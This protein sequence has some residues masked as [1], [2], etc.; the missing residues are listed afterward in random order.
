MM[1]RNLF[2][3]FLLLMMS[4]AA[5]SQEA[6]SLQVQEYVLGNGMKVWLNVDHSQ[7]K[8]FGAV[9]VN[10]GAVDCPDTGIAHYFE[11][12]MFKG[13][14][15]LGTVDYAAERAYLDSISMKYD[16]L[17]RTTDENHRKTIQHDINELN[18][19][20]SQYAIPNEFNRLISKYGGSDLNAGTSYDMTYY[21]NTFSPQYIEQW[22]ELN[23]HR[24]IHP[25]YRLFQGELETVYEEKNMYSDDPL[26]ML[27][28]QVTS[29]FF[30]GTP[31][32][33]P[34][35]GSTEN[36]KNPRLSDMEAFYKKFYVGSNMGL[37]LSGDINPDGLLPVLERTFG[38]IE[39][40]VKPV[41][42]KIIAPPVEG[43]PVEKVLFPLPLVGMSGLL[44]RAPGEF[45]ADAPA[46]KVVMSLLSNDNKTGLLDELSNNNRVYLA[47]AQ[48]LAFNQTGAVMVLV[49]PKLLCRVKTAENLCL[50]QIG[51][52]LKGDFT[53]EQLQAVKLM[54]A[55]DNMKELESIAG[56]SELMVAAMAAGMNWDDYLKW[57]D[58]VADV[59]RDEVIAT[60]RKYFTE[61]FYRF[62]KKNGRCKVEQIAKPEFTAVKPL[63][64]DAK[65]TFAQ[66]LEQLPVQNVAPRLLDLEKDAVR[67]ELPG[68][69]MLFSHD[70]PVNDNFTLVFSFHKGTR[71]D[72]LLEAAASYV[73]E[74]GTDSLDV[75]ALGIALQTLGA[76]L[77]FTA[78][79]QMTLVALRGLDA[80]FEPTLRLLSHF[81]DHMKADKDK[82]DEVKTAVGLE[83]KSF[84]EDNT[85]VF[86]ALALKVARGEQSDYLTR[87][88]SKE[89]KKFKPEDL[90]N[91]FKQLYDYRYDVSYT[92]NIPSE[93]VSD[94]IASLLPQ[95]A[96]TLDNPLQDVPLMNP[97]ERVVYLFDMPDSRQTIV[98]L[99]RP[100]A[101]VTSERDKAC[102]EWWGEYFGGGMS[103]VLFQQV[104]EFRSLAYASQGVAMKPSLANSTNSCCYL[105]LI[106]T[107]GDKAMQAVELL[108]SLI[109]DMPVNVENMDVARQSL[110]N[111]I[112]NS[113][114]TFRGKSL[115]IPLLLRSGYHEDRCAAT[116]RQLSQLTQEDILS[117]YRQH[118]KDQ[119]CQ[120]MIVGNL[121]KMDLKSLAR[122]G[123]I[124]KVKKEDIYRTKPVKK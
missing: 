101:A 82:F 28:E 22:C 43:Q 120:L 10:A 86:G 8:V 49:V 26:A 7:P 118:V 71:Q 58:H 24:L 44:F 97:Q 60:A 91:S 73:D 100:L 65:S 77:S 121:K 37:I 68:G 6:A 111:D 27:L 83:E 19:K 80:N 112:N 88:T 3:S 67:T 56:R 66:R 122:Y 25:V 23:S 14:D 48:H 108:D 106:A 62:H 98:G 115:L 85:E 94:M 72:K 50:E 96:G 34:I 1:K 117:F 109:N 29:K 4:L 9:V 47:T 119:T 55:S 46:L 110:L 84:M 95:L 20:A 54:I 11:H 5:F 38:Q 70:N 31:Y 69:N 39:R 57:N 104:R 18:V 40:G 99:Y 16:E 107:Q 32:A 33:Y 42:E 2:I 102:L 36:L 13:T 17:A 12:I 75:K 63:H 35:V 76:K 105:A 79:D 61:N 116:A 93:Q 64:A 59:S 123:T 21:H 30:T 90:I 74:L 92:G 41:R 45:D 78:D 89:L 15:E 113:Y 52:L 103:S 124:V 114:P 81:L 53:D 87:L 51:K